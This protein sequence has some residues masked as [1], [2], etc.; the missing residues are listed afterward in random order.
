M[1][2]AISVVLGLTMVGCSSYE[3]PAVKAGDVCF[4]CAR[5]VT[6]AKLGVQMLRENGQLS[7]FR[8]PACLATYLQ[9]NEKVA[10]KTIYVTDYESGEMFPVASAKF[11]RVTIDPKSHE[12]DFYAFKSSNAAAKFAA[13]HYTGVVDWSAIR[14]MAAAADKT[15]E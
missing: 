13:E 6:D 11:V 14:T 5:V 9:D 10:V 3:P 15:G 2:Y 8:T 1:R 7:T 4:R 12:R